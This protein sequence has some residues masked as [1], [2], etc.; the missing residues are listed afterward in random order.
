MI[1]YDEDARVSLIVAAVW[2]VG[3]GIGWQLLKK[4]NPQI[5]TRTPETASESRTPESVGESR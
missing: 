2:A 5:T 4:R 3:L 1:A